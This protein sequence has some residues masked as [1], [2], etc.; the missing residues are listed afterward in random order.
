MA[1][2]AI[3]DVPK[4][5]AD[6]ALIDAETYARYYAEAARDPNGFWS[7]EAQRIDWITPFH[8]VKDT[9]FAEAD[10]R[11]NWFAD[12]QL[13]V[14]ANCLDRHLAERGDTTAIIWEGDDPADIRRIS[15]SELHADVCRLANLL[16]QR[17]VVKGDRVTIYLPMI[18]EAAVAMLACA[19]IGAIHSVVFGGFSPDSL[20]NRIADCDSRLVITADEGCR[21]GKRVA[22]KANVDVALG[23]AECGGVDTVIVVRR[24][25]GRVAMQPDRDLWY[26]AATADQPADCPAEPM[27]AED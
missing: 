24:T 4:A 19:R 22:L 11:I 12:G 16:T 3:H 9:S 8:A 25:G 7:R 18:P 17:G 27:N 26:D 14:A 20:A 13:N 23:R 10:F 5:W 1:D 15:Y 21:G 6:T 2:A